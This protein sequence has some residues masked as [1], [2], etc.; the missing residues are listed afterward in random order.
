MGDVG[1]GRLLLDGTGFRPEFVAATDV[2]L[3]RPCFEIQVSPT[4]P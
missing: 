3:G 1:V 4:A 2:M